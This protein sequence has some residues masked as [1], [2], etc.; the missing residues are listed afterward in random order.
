[1][2]G[3]RAK[4]KV[5]LQDF[6]PSKDIPHTRRHFLLRMHEGELAC[7][8]TTTGWTHRIA[9][10]IA[11]FG[12]GVQKQSALFTRIEDDID[13][14]VQGE[15]PFGFF[16][17]RVDEMEYV[18][19]TKHFADASGGMDDAL[20]GGR[21]NRG[22]GTQMMLDQAVEERTTSIG[23]AVHTNGGNANWSIAVH[24]AGQEQP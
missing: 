9:F 8:Y 7:K 22:L 15:W 21:L 24:P 12:R 1:M 11:H 18:R 23:S 3:L 4:R 20:K 5:S 16:E 13:V 17:L 10:A 14:T 19:V 2:T 6:G